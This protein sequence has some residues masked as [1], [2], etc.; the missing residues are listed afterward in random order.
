MNSLVNDYQ[1]VVSSTDTETYIK[2]MD[3]WLDDIDGHK[4]KVWW[5]FVK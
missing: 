1:T 4:H 2:M 5:Y 3:A